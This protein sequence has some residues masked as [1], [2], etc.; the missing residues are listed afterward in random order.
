[1]LKSFIDVDEESHFPIQNLPYGIFRPK[2]KTAPRA[3]VAI[4][5]WILDLS[6]LDDKG[7]FNETGAGG[8]RVF[9]EPSLNAFMNLGPNV[10]AEVR[11]VL[12]D[13]LREDNPEIRD[14]ADLR[15]SLFS[16]QSGV[17]MLMPVEIRDYTD[18]YASEQHATNVGTM[19]RGRENALM[20][21][22]K[23]LPVGYHGR[24]S[25]IIVSGT[26]IKRPLGQRKTEGDQPEFGPSM[27]LDFELEMGLV[28]GHGNE[29]GSR[30]PVEEAEEH[31]FGLVLVNDWSARDIQAWEYQPLGPFLSKSFATSISPWIVP[32]AALEPFRTA[33]PKQDP[34]PLPYLKGS[35]DQTFDI[36]LEAHLKIPGL[37]EPVV[38]TETNFRTLYWSMAQ[39]IAHHTVNGCNLNAGDLLASGTISGDEKTSRGCMLERTWR[40]EEPLQLPNGEKRV[41]LEDGDELR[42]TGWCQADGYRVGFGQ[43]NSR[44]L[45]TQVE[46]TKGGSR[47]AVLSEKG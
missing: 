25:S 4:G 19:F 36:H 14:Q 34:E 43:V 11:T 46:E 7:Y 30:I 41:W 21:N 13:L 26:E 29:S 28:I 24:A 33:G 44:I 40:G 3:G 1:M 5:D 31:I 38:V 39:Q 35:G 20:P 16:R 32:M 42:L 8:K 17:D 2:G 12:Q 18:F 45:P 22:W 23:H 37:S 27:R 6:I 9:S 10:W 47:D 15:D